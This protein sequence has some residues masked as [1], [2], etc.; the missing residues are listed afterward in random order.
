[1]S[2]SVSHKRAKRGLGLNQVLSSFSSSSS[3]SSSSPTAPP[4][5][6]PS[7]VRFTQPDHELH[8][9]LQR[10]SPSAPRDETAAFYADADMDAERREMEEEA[11]RLPTAAYIAARV[12]NARESVLPIPQLFSRRVTS[13]AEALQSS[14]STA[15]NSNTLSNEAPTSNEGGLSSSQ[16]ASLKKWEELL[17]SSSMKNTSSFSSSPSSSVFLSS[18]V[19]GLAPRGS[20]SKKAAAFKSTHSF[21][22]PEKDTSFHQ[23]QQQG[24]PISPRAQSSSSS[25]TTTAATTTA[26]TEDVR[27]VPLLQDAYDNASARAIEL[28]FKYSERLV[29]TPRLLGSSTTDQDYVST[30]TVADDVVALPR[31][32]IKGSSK[33]IQGF[34]ESLIDASS[35]ERVSTINSRIN[36]GSNIGSSQNDAD[37]AL[38]F[39]EHALQLWQLTLA[40]FSTT[41]SGK[42]G[43][44]N[45]RVLSNALRDPELESFAQEAEA[46]AKESLLSNGTNTS[47]FAGRCRT[48]A[49]SQWLQRSLLLKE[50]KGEQVTRTFGELFD[51]IFESLTRRDLLKASRLALSGNQPILSSF[52]T[53]AGTDKNVCVFLQRQLRQWRASSVFS[54]KLLSCYSLIAGPDEDEDGVSNDELWLSEVKGAEISWLQSFGLFL[55]YSGEDLSSPDIAIAKYTSAV[56]QSRV[57][58]PLPWWRA[59]EPK[60][61]NNGGIVSLKQEKKDLQQRLGLA[62]SSSSSFSQG[63]NGIEE[64]DEEDEDILHLSFSS[65]SSSSSSLSYS[66]DLRSKCA[67]A[68]VKLIHNSQS[69]NNALIVSPPRDALYM[70]L[71]L[72]VQGSKD[73]ESLQQLLSPYSHCP[74]E[75]ENR[76]SFLLYTVLRSLGRLSKPRADLL[77]R[78]SLSAQAEDAASSVFK[79]V[80]S[81]QQNVLQMLSREMHPEQFEE[82]KISSFQQRWNALCLLYQ[83]KE[84][85]LSQPLLMPVILPLSQDDYIKFAISSALKFEESNNDWP[86]AILSLLSAAGQ[87]LEEAQ[88]CSEDN[89][90]NIF[91]SE[92]ERT[93]RTIIR[94]AIALLCRHVP[95]STSLLS[96]HHS[97]SDSFIE[98]CNYLAQLGWPLPHTW[99]AFAVAVRGVKDA[100]IPV[101]LPALI[102][103]LKAG[104]GSPQTGLISLAE[105]DGGFSKRVWALS[106]LKSMLESEILPSLTTPL[107]LPS[108]YAHLEQ[109][110]DLMWQSLPNGAPLGTGNNGIVMY[111]GPGGCSLNGSNV[112][113]TRELHEIVCKIDTE[114]LGSSAAGL[115]ESWNGR[116]RLLSS[117][118]SI[119]PV[120]KVMRGRKI[121]FVKSWAEEVFM[122]EQE[123]SKRGITSLRDTLWPTSKK[124]LQ[125]LRGLLLALERRLGG[126]ECSG[127]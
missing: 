104:G 118:F 83:S 54:R 75:T 61:R 73:S 89:S 57:S 15:V 91:R 120:I 100:S 8:K 102:S 39:S 11:K 13:V 1:M 20:L 124:S 12:R 82:L 79:D 87:A 72:A 38:A 14:S 112:F 127:V 35:K 19:S 99:L 45:A 33:A 106:M 101:A 40:L 116:G 5:R 30:N 64:E 95:S 28:L 50:K 96:K 59:Y 66:S 103:L 34:L 27:A 81:Y 21:S 52:V 92:C 111:A 88:V 37:S 4:A 3:S 123:L 77:N 23:R 62:S 51:V 107:A 86:R 122:N 113:G 74:D 126:E 115:E 85:L 43:N 10:Q 24:P 26:S 109:Q 53:Q 41:A 121:D 65:T 70:L 97:S 76:L 31:F 60:E 56:E 117:I 7:I 105:E 46:L 32:P 9:A 55:W 71:R 119:G 68:K 67:S 110:R 93:S 22:S 44:L 48:E 80:N 25:S 49:L 98:K 108:Y 78:T 114:V 6:G 36:N 42:T 17:S 58:V 69:Y 16:L 63:K 47:L 125:H 94:E 29:L 2:S 90:E 18:L 84:V